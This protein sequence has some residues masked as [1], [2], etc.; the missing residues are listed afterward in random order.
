MAEV[1][2]T[3]L[4]KPGFLELSDEQRHAY[5]N[6]IGKDDPEA[7]TTIREAYVQKMLTI[8]PLITTQ[9]REV[10]SARRFQLANRLERQLM[11]DK[12]MKESSVS[13]GLY[14]IPR[15]IVELIA[16][17]ETLD[18]PPSIFNVMQQIREVFRSKMFNDFSLVDKQKYIEL[19]LQQPSLISTGITRDVILR[20]FD[21]IDLN[22]RA[23]NQIT[24]DPLFLILARLDPKS[25]LRTCET[26]K[27]FQR[28]C[29]NPMLFSALMRTHYP[30]YFETN[31]PKEQYKA[32][33]M[34]LETK[35]LLRGVPGDHTGELFENHPIKVG[36]TELPHHVSGFRLTP[37]SVD[38]IYNLLGPG[39][40]PQV[41]QRLLGKDDEIIYKYYLAYRGGIPTNT[42]ELDKMYE[43]GKLSEFMIRRGMLFANGVRRLSDLVF[44]IKGYPIPAGSNAWLLVQKPPDLTERPKISVFKTK[45]DLARTF[46]DEN[47][48]RLFAEIIES[49]LEEHP[50]MANRKALYDYV[51]T[52][53]FFL[54]YAWSRENVYDFKSVTFWQD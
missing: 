6:S 43:A 38:D 1:A 7:A 10:F 45:E 20:V 41:M 5:F 46:A 23:I 17:Q 18:K 35:Y 13:S 54:F 21:E 16:R 4:D 34:A 51:M 9:L 25:A 8:N 26:T 2:I 11:V 14:R 50:Y 12:L 53:D 3:Q 44:E 31:N 40:V 42:E 33:T 22:T 27:K 47:Y 15:E 24:G 52:E 39:Y 49:S 30:L 37:C 36:K 32:I 48:D 29:Q 28:L 19:M